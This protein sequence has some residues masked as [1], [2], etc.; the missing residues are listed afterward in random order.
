M[1]GTVEPDRTREKKRDRERVRIAE[2][3]QKKEREREREKERDGENPTEKAKGQKRVLSPKRECLE[4]KGSGFRAD[5]VLHPHP[6]HGISTWLRI[7]TCLGSTA[8]CTTGKWSTLYWEHLTLGKG[9]LILG[10]GIKASIVTPASR[11]R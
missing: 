3:K 9:G 2:Q 11:L 7:K 5:G 8:W 1:R 6:Q 10:E 4:V